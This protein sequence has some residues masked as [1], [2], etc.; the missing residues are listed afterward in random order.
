MMRK[1]GSGRPGIFAPF[2]I[3]NRQCPIKWGEG[4]GLAFAELSM[5]ASSIRNT[6]QTLK[7]AHVRAARES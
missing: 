7:S 4:L 1:N 6:D 2:P 3:G 5:G